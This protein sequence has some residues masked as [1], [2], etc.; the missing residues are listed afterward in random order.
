MTEYDI[1]GKLVWWAWSKITKVILDH[2]GVLSSMTT[3]SFE[4]KKMPEQV[5]H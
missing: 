2:A 4:N 5:G 1:F 3:L